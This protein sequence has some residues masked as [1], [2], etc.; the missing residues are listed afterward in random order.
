MT[1]PLQSVLLFLLIKVGFC[2]IK[3]TQSAWKSMFINGSIFDDPAIPSTVLNTGSKMLCASIANNLL[4]PNVFY[5]NNGIC[6]LAAVIDMT[7]CHNVVSEG[8]SLAVEGN[9]LLKGKH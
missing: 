6:R 1:L 4:W 9:W 7:S 5:F 2:H 3:L 8:S